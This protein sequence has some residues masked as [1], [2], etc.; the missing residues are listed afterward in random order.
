MPGLFSR[1]K[2]WIAIEFLTHTDLNAEFDNIIAKSTPT[3]IDDASSTVADMKETLDPGEV[4]SEV[5]AQSFLEEIQQLRFQLKEISGKD[6]WYE[7]PGVSMATLMGMFSVPTHRIISGREDSYGQPMFLQADGVSPTVRLK[8]ND[9]SLIGVIENEV[10]EFDLDLQ[11]TDL[12]V[13]PTS[14]NTCLVNRVSLAGE[15]YS[16]FYGEGDFALPIDNI[17]AEIALRNG[18]TCAFKVQHASSFEYF[19]AEVDLTNNVLKNGSRGFFFNELDTVLPRI[20][21]FDND[22]ITLLNIGYVFAVNSTPRVLEVTYD[23]PI[24]SYDEPSGADYWF[25]LSVNKWKKKSGSSFVEIKAIYLG[26]VILDSESAVAAR[27]V[28]LFRPFD[29]LN[30]IQLSRVDAEKVCSKLDNS[31]V[32]VYGKTFTYSS[33]S[34]VWRMATDRDDGV[35]EAAST[36]YFFYLTKDGNQVISDVA[37]QDRYHDLRGAYHPSKPW[38]CVGQV[39]ND[40]ASDFNP[41]VASEYKETPALPFQI[42][43]GAFRYLYD[44]TARDYIFT[45]TGADGSDPSV[46]N[47]VVAYFPKSPG[48]TT[49]ILKKVFATPLSIYLASGDDLGFRNASVALPSTAI[50][51]MALFLLTKGEQLLLGMGASNVVLPNGYTGYQVIYPIGQ[52][53][54][55]ESYVTEASLASGSPDWIVLQLGRFYRNIDASLWVPPPFFPN[56]KPDFGPGSLTAIV[57]AG[58]TNHGS[59]TTRVR[60]FDATAGN[61]SYG[62]GLGYI[63]QVV[64]DAANGTVI[65]ILR[66]GNFFLSFEDSYSGG[67]ATVGLALTTSNVLTYFQYPTASKLGV[68]QSPTG[69]RGIATFTGHLDLGVRVFPVDAGANDDASPILRIAYLGEN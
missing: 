23:T 21:I 5:Q 30:T 3:Y 31:K 14:D 22:V 35:T 41:Q 28:D 64:T 65:Y 24:V 69:I 11:A 17:G 12:V 48:A 2:N 26:K 51:S 20:P 66:K 46:I 27:S 18:K 44:T 39:F 36:T 25:D 56:A 63:Y 15:P 6:E 67:T 1:I 10:V 58:V 38:R 16:K 53:K 43:N 33:L 45:L 47:P 32:S 37:P 40:I 7:V 29:S 9:T 4:G 60:R 34:H 61:F 50:N 19:L 68:V 54:S 13:A 52:D 59:T 57:G 62:D 8:A 49:A 55:I 42:Q